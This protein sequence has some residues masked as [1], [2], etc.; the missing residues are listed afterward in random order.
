MESKRL[1]FG[2]LFNFSPKW[3]GGV[4]YIINVIKTLDFLDDSEKPEIYLFYRPDLS[5]FLNEM[6]YPYLKLVKWEFPSMIKGSLK[7]MLV[8]KNLFIDKLLKKYD[9]DAVYPLQDYPVRTNGKVKLVSWCADFQQNHYPE[10]FTKMQRFGRN[11][12]TRLALRNTNDLVLSSNDAYNDLKTFFKVPGK[13]NIHIFH[14]VSV[15]DKLE[16]LNINDLKI[17]YNLPDNYFMVSNQFHKHKNHKALLLALVK[18]NEI[19]I[20]KHIAMTGKLPDASDSP[21]LAELHNIINDNKLQDQISLLGIISRSDQLQIMRHS[22]AVIQPS[23]FEGWSTVIEDAKSLQVPVIASN[24]KVNI[25]QLG[26]DG[27]YFDP[28]K[29]DELTSVLIKFPERNLNDVFYEDYPIRIKAAAR[30]LLAILKP[31]S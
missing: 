1:K 21:Y 28:H 11:T 25:E 29:P 12:R 14:F 17:K 16:Y 31:V 26:K 10:F 13:L 24:L 27:I 22:Q 15:I 5:R 19:G 30:E 9:L 3:M 23:L 6:K 18:L 7:S 4:I 2:I 8:R 20:K